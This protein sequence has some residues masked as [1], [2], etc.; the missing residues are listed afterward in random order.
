VASGSMTSKTFGGEPDQYFA[1]LPIED[2]LQECERRVNDYQ[3]Y[4]LRTGKLTTWRTNWEM[5]MRSEMKI[6]IRFGGDR[7]Q[8]KLIES[9]I[10]RSIVTGLVSTIANQRPSFQ[11]EAIND[12]HKSMSQD[13][14]FDSVSNYY[15]K[16]KHMEDGYKKGLTYGLVM[17]EGWMFEKWNAD[18]GQVTDTVQDPTGKEV[19]IKEGDAQFTIL[20]PMDVIRDY[21]RMD[22]DND[23]YIAREYLNKWDLI[24]QRPDLL[25]ELKGYS[26]PTTLQRFRFGHIVDAQTSNS[27]LIPVYTFI[28]RKTPACPEGRITTYID[29]D[30]WILD[31]ALPYDEIPLYPMMPDET[32]LNNFGSTVMTSLVKL[33]YAYDKTLSVIV[34]NQQAFAITNIVIDESTQTKPEQVIEG[35]N[36]IK[37]NMKNGVPVGLEL[38]KTPAE[39][40]KFLDL[41]ESQMEK[42]SG[43]P[44]I[45]RG[46][47]PTGVE[48]GSA[49]AFLQAQALV[50]NSPIQ[51][52]YI[53]FLERSATGLF[54]ML[55]SFANTKRMITIAGS[56]KSAY[57]G[58][59]SGQDL[60]N[61]S[62]VIVSAGNP[63]TRSEAG[64][65]QIAQDLMAK[66][67]IKDANQYFEVLA[68]GEL[69]PMVEGPEAEN[70]LII[71][72]NE[73]L[74]RGLPQVAAP[75]DNH[76]NH[77]NQHF[78]IMMDPAL[79]QKQND[80]VMAATMQH[81][82]SHAAFIFP[83]IQAPTD[84]RLMGLMGNNVQGL[85]PGAPPAPEQPTPP[86]VANPMPAGAA[87][88]ANNKPPLLQAAGAVKLPHAPILP[89]ATPP[90]VATAASQ[91]GN[92]ALPKK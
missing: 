5:W 72:E 69:D 29:S 61:I 42:L 26:M 20:P 25:D 10:Y 9:N 14:V 19:P 31:T 30:T 38:C 57:M 13:I 39:V 43:L 27:D 54:N 76:A 68:T 86:P 50:F 84:P 21:T 2:L 53:S 22:V 63:A 8:Y 34:T 32:I 80:P 17:G 40:F 16:V 89:R 78:V 33:Q 81:I 37:T 24:A 18:I 56:S 62:R 7:G 75:W 85:P 91:M 47:P 90:M 41:L 87:P 77:I 66:G 45:L 35:L 12:D 70:M 44:S 60:S 92:A 51:Q 88:V 64:K 1:T 55:K 74:R 23:W 71:K 3:D 6:G 82:M 59:F 79:R 48:S 15:L 83:G 52:A 49:M 67:L 46:Q 36:F 4:V 65:L 73:Q 11:P 28:H 58:E